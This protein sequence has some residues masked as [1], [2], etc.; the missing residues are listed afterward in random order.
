MNFTIS[1]PPHKKSKITVQSIMWN[2]VIALL[3]IT[4]ASIYFFGI[5]ALN[6]LVLSILTAAVTEIG[7]QAIFRQKSTIKDGNALWIGLMSGLLMPPEVPLWLPIVCS[8]FAIA[9]GKH[10]FGGIGSYFFN[11]VLAAWIFCR[12]AWANYLTAASLP[13]TGHL[14]NF[15][16]ESGAGFL[17]EVSPILII[18]GGLYL[19][20]RRYIEWRIPLTFGITILL[21]PQVLQVIFAVL[22]LV[23]QGI[24]NPLMYLAQFFKFFDIS[25]QLHYSMVGMVFFG[26]FFLATDSP[27]SPVTKKG[28]MIYGI[29]CGLLVSI[30]GYFANYVEATIFGLFLANCVSSFIEV[31]TVPPVYGTKSYLVKISDRLLKKSI[32]FEGDKAD[33]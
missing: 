18:I 24:L 32:K 20:F 7:I 4:I 11:P 28:R 13:Y 27:S 31:N 17:V 3:P 5:P 33:E 25:P 12:T 30:Y 8:F 6:I 10:A 29:I 1:A 22:S 21:F 15:I 2:K 26:I 9:I 19:I 16:L 23:D 14:S